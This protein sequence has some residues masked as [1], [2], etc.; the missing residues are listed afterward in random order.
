VTVKGKK[1]NNTQGMMK[2]GREKMD[3]WGY[4]YFERK[5]KKEPFF[6]FFYV[7]PRVPLTK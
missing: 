3:G 1:V 5:K 4:I 7:P 6:F 2:N